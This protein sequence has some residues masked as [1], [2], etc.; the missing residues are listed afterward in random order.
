MGSSGENFRGVL[1]V[2]ITEGSKEFYLRAGPGGFH[3]SAILDSNTGLP[4]L[5]TSVAPKKIFLYL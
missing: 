2:D 3:S 5:S 1:K 4:S